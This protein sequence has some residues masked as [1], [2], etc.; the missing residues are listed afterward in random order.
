MARDGTQS[1]SG[2][3]P[4]RAGI[5]VADDFLPQELAQAMRRDLEAHFANPMGQPAGAHQVWNYWFVPQLY[6][7]LR[8]T[9]E[10]VIERERVDAF[11]RALRG[12]SLATLGLGAAT[13]PYLSLYVGG[14][15]QAWHND[16][17]T[18][19]FAFVYSL[20]KNQRQAIGGE[21]LILPEGD[22]FRANLAR[23]TA[24]TGLYEAVEPRFNRLIVFDDRLAHAVSRVDGV[25]DPVEGRCVLHGHLREAATAVSGALRPEHV[26]EPLAAALRAFVADAPAQL[27]LYH[28][29]LAVRLTIGPSGAVERCAALLDRVMHPDPGNTEWEPLLARLIDCLGAAQ[30]PPADGQTT[31]I[32]PV[33]FGAPVPRRG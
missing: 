33:M 16:A 4:L 21:T 22:P 11:M 24:G 14:C 13:W 27:A 25:M 6:T 15:G 31:I 5:I 30:F 7:Q 8:T 20:T 9:P 12:W 29:P 26:A 17:T 19:R 32:Q 28:G 2:A 10:K 23:P 18:G 1:G 3:A